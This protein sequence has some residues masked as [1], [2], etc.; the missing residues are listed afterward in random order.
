MNILYGTHRETVA[1]PVPKDRSG[2][3]RAG[4][5]IKLNFCGRK[6]LVWDPLFDPPNPPE[7]YMRVLCLRP[8]LGNEAHNFLGGPKMGCFGWGPKKLC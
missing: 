8:F 5:S 7:K 4:K 3:V 2:D 6:C 1:R